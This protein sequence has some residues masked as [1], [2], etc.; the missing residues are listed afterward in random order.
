MLLYIIGA[1]IVEILIDDDK[2]IKGVQIGDHEIKIV[3]FADD[4]PFSEERLP[5]LRK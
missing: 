4:T 3:I 2:R 5:A 1:E